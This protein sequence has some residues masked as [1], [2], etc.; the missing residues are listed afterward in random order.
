MYTLALISTSGEPGV[1]ST[2]ILEKTI[3]LSA[4]DRQL[5]NA[6]KK[7]KFQI[8]RMMEALK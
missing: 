7:S 3:K 2:E 6:L 8:E 5:K 4:L 1:T